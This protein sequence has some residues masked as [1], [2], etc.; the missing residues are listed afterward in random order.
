MIS[1]GELIL[2]PFIDL[3]GDIPQTS[4]WYDS[5]EFISTV[6]PLAIDIGIGVLILVFVLICITRIV[7]L[8]R[9]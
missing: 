4:E 5:F 2:G 9:G 6:A 8:I 3:G 7:S 1:I